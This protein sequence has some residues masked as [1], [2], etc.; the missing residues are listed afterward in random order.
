MC[1]WDKFC[2]SIF[3]VLGHIFEVSCAKFGHVGLKKS[4]LDQ[5]EIEINLVEFVSLVSKWKES[6]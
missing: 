2:A 1:E 4:S 6:I 3:V 5:S